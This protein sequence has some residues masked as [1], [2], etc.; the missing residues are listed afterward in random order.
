MGCLPDSLV[1]QLFA[2]EPD[3]TP[4]V[5]ITLRP[6]VYRACREHGRARSGLPAIIT[7]VIGQVALSRDGRLHPNGQP[8]MPRD[9]LEPIDRDSFVIGAQADLDAFL[10]GQDIN[11]FEPPAEFETL[12]RI[13]TGS[14][15]TTTCRPARRWSTKWPTVGME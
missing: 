8:L 12:R 1:T 13:G 3:D 15:G 9:I 2:N 4:L 11:R 6:W 5:E 14:S 7:P 10:S